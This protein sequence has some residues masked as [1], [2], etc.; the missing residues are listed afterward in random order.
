MNMLGGT[1]KLNLC[2]KPKG[3]QDFINKISSYLY[4]TDLVLFSYP[5]MG[6]DAF[7]TCQIQ[8]GS[9]TLCL[10][11]CVG[12]DVLL[13]ISYL[14]SPSFLWAT[15]WISAGS[16]F[17]PAINVLLCACACVYICTLVRMCVPGWT[18]SSG[19]ARS[20]WIRRF[21]RSCCLTETF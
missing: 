15:S 18:K 9:T 10:L 3:R 6:G 14:H 17:L 12:E 2:C 16:I 8:W 1:T 5:Y 7:M 21:E 13:V 19:K 4:H 20:P 11:L